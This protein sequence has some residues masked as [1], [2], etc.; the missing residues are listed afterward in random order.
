MRRTSRQACLLCPWARHL[1]GCLHLY[2]AE[3]WWGQAVYLSWWPSLTKDLQTVHE[4]SRSVCT[5]CCIMLRTNSS[6]DDEEE[7]GKIFLFV[8]TACIS[9]EPRTSFGQLSSTLF[10]SIFLSSDTLSTVSG[11]SSTKFIRD[12]LSPSRSESRGYLV[13]RILYFCKS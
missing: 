7:D 2:V 4:C 5:S 13:Y 11:G 6:S 9:T 10:S 1:T 8:A 12:S 3:R